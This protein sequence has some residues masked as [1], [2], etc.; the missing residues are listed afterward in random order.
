MIDGKKVHIKKT[1]KQITQMSVFFSLS[2]RLAYSQGYI[3]LCGSSDCFEV[4]DIDW[5]S[6]DEHYL[7]EEE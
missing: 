3:L 5:L 1:S 7:T 4:T 6:K 2:E